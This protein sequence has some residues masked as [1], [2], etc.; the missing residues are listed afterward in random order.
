M[1]YFRPLHKPMVELHSVF[2]ISVWF[3]VL[4]ATIGIIILE[5]YHIFRSLQLI[6]GPGDNTFYLLISDPYVELTHFGIMTPYG[7]MD[8]DQH[9]P[10]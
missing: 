9:W 6:Q 5:P 4:A 7:D 10:R 8:L 1:F 3:V 2:V